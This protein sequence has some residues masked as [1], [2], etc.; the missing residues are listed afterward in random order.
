MKKKLEEREAE[1]Q[2]K[3][4]GD[5]ER[6]EEKR[7]RTTVNARGKHQRETEIGLWHE[8]QPVCLCERKNSISKPK[9]IIIGRQEPR[10]SENGKLKRFER[11]ERRENTPRW[12][13][14]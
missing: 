5:G 12:E 11:E 3:R 9:S 10:K 8:S 13:R 6:G 14:R 7:P 1:Q 2:T 4:V